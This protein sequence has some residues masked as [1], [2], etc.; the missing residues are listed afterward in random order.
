MATQRLV[1]MIPTNLNG[2]DL[3][4]SP[5]VLL[6]LFLTL[7]PAVTRAQEQFDVVVYGGT[8][9]GVIAAVQAGRMGKSAA[10]VEPT[11]HLGGMT[12]GGLGATDMGNQGAIGGASREFYGRIFKHY[13]DPA[14]WKQE[15][16]K[17]YAKRER[18]IVK[19]AQF[20]FE[21]KVAEQILNDMAKEANV[22]VF[23][24]QRLDLK[25]GGVTKEG[26]RVTSFKTE[27]GKTFKAR[28]FIDGSYEG[29]LFVKAGC[30]YLLGR[31]ANAQFNETMNGVQV[32]RAKSHQFGQKVDPYVKP[33]DRGSGLVPNIHGGDPG[34]DGEADKRIQAYNFR[35]CVT[36]D[37]AN[38]VPF[39]KPEGYDEREFELLLRQYE[40]G[41][42]GVPWGPRGMPNRKT[43]TNNSG[44]F[45]TDYI[46]MNYDYPEGDWATRDKIVLAHVKYTQGLLWTL[47]NHPRVPEKVRGNVSR[48][49]WARDEFVDTNN[50]P[51]QL[52]IRE[53][54]RLHGPYV[55]SEEDCLHKRTCEDPI[56]LGSYN[57]DSHNTQRYVDAEGQARNEGDV[58][59]GPRGP[60]GI[61]YRA[62]Q[63]KAEECTNL[64]VPVSMSSTHIAFGSI[65]MEPVFMIMGQACGTAAS[66]AIDDNVDVQKVSYPKLRERLVADKAIVEWSGPVRAAG[67]ASG[68]HRKL[69]EFEGTV[70]DDARAELTG[71]WS[72]GSNQGIGEGY[73]HD[74]NTDKGK[75]SAKWEVTIP[76]D[77]RYEVRLGYAPNP[78]RAT[79]VPVTVVSAEG[80]KKVTV[81]Q[82]LAPPLDRAFVSLGT[83]R[84]T[85][86][87][88]AVVTVSN[89][90]TDG[91]VI[92]DAVQ[93]LPAK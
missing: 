38:Q 92:I 40:A 78:N 74:A 25:P 59:V 67:A 93:V 82:K 10:V 1:G 83:Y 64:L 29:D 63:P 35:L 33:G 41:F 62:L 32:A 7:L 16:R 71:E 36:D 20:G 21:P 73:R 17:D 23:L 90:G 19:D 58:Q 66:M 27:G 37:K 69:S 86:A 26:T 18:Y 56:G 14:A 61:S 76:A 15:K 47:A 4:F 49:G 22:K 6:S 34:K 2:A 68:G 87:K 24:G 50:F 72:A 42:S 51:R 45:S 13:E 53:A 11:Q 5:R 28:V 54:R 89:E 70:V 9:G 39:A 85:A 75:K 30:S 48:W 12:T 80:E 52:Y 88:P 81:N 3:M 46:G 31:E 84:F 79:N 60:Y 44:A 55:V 77:G 65:R 91:Y 57:M 8:A 43:D